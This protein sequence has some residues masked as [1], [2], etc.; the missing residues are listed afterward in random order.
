MFAMFG[1]EVCRDSHDRRKRLT[2]KHCHAVRVIHEGKIDAK[3]YINKV[4]S[5]E[6]LV[7]EDIKIAEAGEA[8]KVVIIP[9]L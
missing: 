9:L 4:V 7:G 8:L 5:L 3:K 1:L 6:N 2:E